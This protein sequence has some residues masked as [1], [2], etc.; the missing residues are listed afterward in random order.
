MQA[1][2]EL[3]GYSQTRTPSGVQ[4]NVDGNEIEAALRALGLGP[5]NTLFIHSS[6]SSMG[7]VEGGAETAVAA[8]LGILGSEGTLAAPTFDED[9]SADV[10][11]P[12]TDPS[13]LGSISEAIRTHRDAMHSTDMHGSVAAIGRN[14][15]EITAVFGPS[16]WAGDGPLWQLY[17]LDAYILLLG[18][19]YRTST[20][21]HVIEQLVQVPY[22]EWVTDEG[23]VREPDGGTRRCTI[24]EYVQTSDS[25]GND[26]NKFGSALEQR[27]LV[28]LGLV[29]NAIARL[30]RARDALAVGVEMYRQDAMTFAKTGAERTRLADGVEIARDRCVADPGAVYVAE[31]GHV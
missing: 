8:L 12:A 3:S 19:T 24:R 29:G 13:G 25:P 23:L 21:F 18:V 14:A 5:G 22:R 26:F 15:G 10:F 20:F 7:Y 30:F 28:R 2:F 9:H 1:R 16:F 11:D 6:L 27:G 4:E 31:H 17:A